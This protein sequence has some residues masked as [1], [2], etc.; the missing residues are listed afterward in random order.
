MYVRPSNSKQVEPNY[1]PKKPPKKKQKKN[2]EPLL[3]C[4][5]RYIVDLH[6][7]KQYAPSFPLSCSSIRS[8]PAGPNHVQ[9]IP[10]SWH[11]N[12]LCRME[13]NTVA[14][15]LGVHT[16]TCPL[17]CGKTGEKSSQVPAILISYWFAGNNGIVCRSNQEPSHQRENDKMD[18][19]S[20]NQSLCTL[21]K[22]GRSPV[23]FHKPGD[24]TRLV[25][26]RHFDS[27]KGTLST[28]WLGGPSAILSPAHRIMYSL[29]PKS[30]LSGDVMLCT[31]FHL[32][33]RTAGG[34]RIRTR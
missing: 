11:G 23:A 14:R 29:S 8:R 15:P 22:A 16:T 13:E 31:S 17:M 34:G 18:A 5:G 12:W 7:S 20:A 9:E 3:Q 24:F 4:T 6:R 21:T 2:W 33:D 27:C 32:F 30:A 19:R 10:H 1:Y 28:R 26:F 25:P